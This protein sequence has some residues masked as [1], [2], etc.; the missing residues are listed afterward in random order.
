MASE[1]QTTTTAS[2]EEL[3][4]GL[5]RAQETADRLPPLSCG[6]RN[7]FSY[8]HITECTERPAR[9]RYNRRRSS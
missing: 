5:R 2:A 4:A 6:C 1:S 3:F 8:R 7:P 9:R